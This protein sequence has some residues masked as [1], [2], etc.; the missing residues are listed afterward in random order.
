MM[1]SALS[2]T[3][4]TALPRWPVAIVGCK[5][6]DVNGDNSCST[7]PLSPVAPCHSTRQP[8]DLNNNLNIERYRTELCHNFQEHGFCKYGNKCQFA[9]FQHELRP[10]TRHRKYKTAMCHTYHVTGLCRYGTRCHFIHDQQDLHQDSTMCTA[11]A[12]SPL[13]SPSICIHSHPCS[14]HPDTAMP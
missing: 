2:C 7:P 5:G 1:A 10:V 9:H 8:T 3:H 11:T 13:V 14:P 4:S 12:T 6:M